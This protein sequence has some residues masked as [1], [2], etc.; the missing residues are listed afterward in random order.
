M[1]EREEEEEE[2]GVK[3]SDLARLPVTLPTL[4]PDAS[5]Q[6]AL[7]SANLQFGLE[8]ER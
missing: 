1:E 5:A 7:C 6:I 4:L 2:Q 3:M 8:L